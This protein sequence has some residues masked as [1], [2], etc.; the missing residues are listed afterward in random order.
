MSNGNKVI[1]GAAVL[2]FL[3]YVAVALRFYARYLK[4]V[5]WGADDWLV[6]AAPVM[7]PRVFSC[8][9]LMSPY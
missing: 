4:D 3:G 5:K 2:I 8:S 1:A 6:V 9:I 7:P